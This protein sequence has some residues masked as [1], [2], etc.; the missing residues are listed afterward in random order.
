MHT[1]SPWAATVHADLEN[2]TAIW[3]KKFQDYTFQAFNTGDSLWIVVIWP[4]KGKMA[5]RAAFGMNSTFEVTNLLDDG[6]LLVINLE[7]R[8]GKYEICVSFPNNDIALLHYKTSF[9]ANFPLLIPFWPRDII[10]LTQNGSVEN[11]NGSIHMSQMGSRSGMLFASLTKP[12]TGSVF[13]FQNLSSFS[14]YCEATKTTLENTVGGTWPEIGFQLPLTEEEPLPSDKAYVVSDAYVVFSTAIIENEIQKTQQFL[15]NLADVYCALP[16]P[17]V[18]Y[19]NWPDITQKCL[20]DL[21]QSR[22]CWTQ[23]KG[24]SYLNAY[25]CDYDTPAEVM[26]QLAVLTPLNE[27]KNWYG[28]IHPLYEELL[29]GIDSFYDPKVKTINRWLPELVDK[30][31]ESEEQKKEMVM[32]SWYLHHPLMNLTRLALSGEKKAK[33]LVLKSVEF[34]IKVAHHFDYE[35]PVF[36][37]MDTLEVIKKET[38]REK[39]VKKMCPDRMHI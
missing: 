24:I 30:L 13:Y 12:K 23:T 9:K 36:Y 5:F 38:I 25:L 18:T 22:G 37:K 32:D 26:V 21:H 39:A 31:D 29:D 35:W 19:N 10:P 8:L 6:E 27:L 15:N 2:N 33:E 3:E 20:V 11:T 16:H 28:E 7:T 4:D 1:I 17:E 14:P 34:A